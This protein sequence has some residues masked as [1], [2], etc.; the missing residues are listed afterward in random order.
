M[1]WTKFIPEA[2]K[3]PVRASAPFRRVYHPLHADRLARTTKR[4]DLC[5]AQ[6]A[7]A[8]HL[9]GDVRLSGA[10]CLELGSGWVLTHALVCHLLGAESVV[11]IDVERAARPQSLALAVS[12][13]V[14]SLIRDLLAPFAEH[15][16]VRARLDRLLSIHRFDFDALAKLGITYVAPIDLARERLPENFD[17]I[18]SF[19]VMEHV[20]TSDVAALL[21]NLK[22]H[23][24]ARGTMLHAIHLEDHRDI[25]GNPFAFLGTRRTPYSRAEET[26][27]GNRLRASAWL[28]AFDATPDLSH[29]LLW[30]WQRHDAALPK[31]LDPAVTFT[32]E[33][34]L[35]TTHIG[36]LVRHSASAAEEGQR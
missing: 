36:V 28:A 3:A 34:D 11:A 16:E 33:E 1:A 15:H 17:L 20:P 12:S 2:I 7:H 5:A 32:G 19:S 29:R 22:G 31:T 9:A 24:T 35:R 6:F 13:A 21:T 26:E 27:R 4:L 23:L 14:P 25:G 10:R 18:S 30:S 8:L